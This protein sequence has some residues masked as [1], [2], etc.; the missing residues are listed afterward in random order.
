[1]ERSEIRDRT[2]SKATPPRASLALNP[3]YSRCSSLLL[4][5]YIVRRIR[6]RE[7]RPGL[8]AGAVELAALGIDALDCGHSC[9]RASAA[10]LH[11]FELEPRNVLLGCSVGT[12]DR[13]ADDPTA[14]RVLPGWAHIMPADGL[15]I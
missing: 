5:E 1:M 7:R 4:Q 11:R 2:I 9:K 14:V 6:R 3:G 10:C 8:F 12:C 13:L 15:A